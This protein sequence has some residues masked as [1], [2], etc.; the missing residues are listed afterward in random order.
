MGRLEEQVV[1]VKATQEMFLT[2]VGEWKSLLEATI[3]SLDCVSGDSLLA[4][5]TMVFLST[6]PYPAREAFRNEHLR[7]VLRDLN[8]PASA[9][10]SMAEAV[11]S[12]S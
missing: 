10:F 9:L 11:P 1:L 6:L 2:E 4:A 12:R 3:K 8:I 7:S 5:A